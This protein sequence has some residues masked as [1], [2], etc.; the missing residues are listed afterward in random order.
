MAAATPIDRR[1]AR[2]LAEMRLAL[3]EGLSLADAR[4]RLAET[5]WAE[6]D[7][8]RRCGTAITDSDAEAEGRFWWQ[9]GNMA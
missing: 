6:R 8:R 4:Q 3:S 9:R 7:A 5:R 2:H 1:R